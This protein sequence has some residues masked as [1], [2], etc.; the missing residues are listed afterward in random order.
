MVK[1]VMNI[2]MMMEQNRWNP[3]I[4]VKITTPFHVFRRMGW[5]KVSPSGKI[6]DTYI[7]IGYAKKVIDTLITMDKAI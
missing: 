3:F 1:Q 5:M 7:C 2:A 6:P 4:F